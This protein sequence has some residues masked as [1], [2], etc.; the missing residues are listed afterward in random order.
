MSKKLRTLQE[1]SLNKGSYGINSAAVSKKQ[2]NDIN[3]LRITDISED[4]SIDSTSMKT[5]EDRQY[6]K[7]L[8]EPN[9]IVYARTGNSV[10]KSYFY[11]KSDGKLVYAGFLIRFSI[12]PNK[13]YPKYI[14]YYSQTRKCKLWIKNVAS[15]GSTRPN[16]NAKELANMVIELPSYE[17]QKKLADSLWKLDQKIKLNNK[18]NANL[19]A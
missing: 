16:I 6:E 17:I 5:L 4:G 18:I 19:V 2:K 1:L 11:D 14:K 12:D 13:V 8:L 3:Y 9:D 7:Y 15:D 10:G